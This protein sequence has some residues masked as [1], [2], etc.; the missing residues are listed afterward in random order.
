M[1]VAASHGFEVV[2]RPVPGYLSADE[3]TPD[4]GAEALSYSLALPYPGVIG[5]YQAVNLNPRTSFSVLISAP[6]DAIQFFQ[7]AVSIQHPNYCFCGA[8][9]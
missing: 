8:G 9:P 7:H 1:K 3:F 2:K 5:A 6:L 4:D